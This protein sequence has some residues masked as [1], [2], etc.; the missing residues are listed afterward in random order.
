MQRG[1]VKK[2]KTKK[3]TENYANSQHWSTKGYN[4]LPPTLHKFK[5]Q[6]TAFPTVLSR[7][8]S[9]QYARC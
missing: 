9:H 5:E 4:V 3:Y 7:P 8:Q 2:K 1:I 6:N